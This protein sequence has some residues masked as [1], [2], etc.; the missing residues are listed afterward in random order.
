[1]SPPAGRT[2]SFSY[3]VTA[4]DTAAALG[5]G[6]VAVLGTPRVLALMEQATVAAVAGDL[7][8][9]QTTVG[10]SVVLDHSRATV[11]GAVVEVTA[12]LDQVSGR[13]LAFDTRVSDA[14]GTAASGRIT[15]ALVDRS[16]FP[17]A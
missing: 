17:G 5:S 3:V 15:R 12:V 7:E 16:R 6:D 8:P 4:A 14:A 13:R 1:M 11:V 9:A 2:A 10:V